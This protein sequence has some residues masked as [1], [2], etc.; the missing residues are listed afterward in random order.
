MCTPEIHFV[1]VSKTITKII[2]WFLLH[3]QGDTITYATSLINHASFDHV[4]H[5]RAI[6]AHALT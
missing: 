6:S 2:T 5:A 4:H 3:C 1:S